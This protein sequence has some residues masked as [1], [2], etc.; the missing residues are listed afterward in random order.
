MNFKRVLVE[1][2][3]L[4]AAAAVLGAGTNLFRP[5]SRKLA[6]RGGYASAGTASRSGPASSATATGGGAGAELLSLAPPKD[7]GLV[8]LDIPGEI[9]HRLHGAGAFFIDARRSAAYA[10]GHISGAASIPVWEHDA[11]DRVAALMA[12]GKRPDEV[13]V[14]YCSGGACEDAAMLAGKLSQAGFYN[15]YLYKDGFPAW[16]SRGW[17]VQRGRQP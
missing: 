7:P 8:Y 17:P 12:Q 3:V 9:A 10:E 5:E 11:D 2:G 13:I 4:I 16:Q 14:V 15:V 1:A 6:W